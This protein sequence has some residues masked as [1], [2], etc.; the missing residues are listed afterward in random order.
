MRDVGNGAVGVLVERVDDAVHYLELLDARDI[1]APDRIAGRLDEV[2]HRRRDPELE[3]V[4]GLPEPI[5]FGEVLGPE[6]GR[7]RL[8]RGDRILLEDFLPGFHEEPP[9]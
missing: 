1:L 3:I 5:E 4:G 6:L 7:Q 2:H 8:E 9:L